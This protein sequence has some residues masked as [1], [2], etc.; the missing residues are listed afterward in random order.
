M[1]L[2]CYTF[3]KVQELFTHDYGEIFNVQLP[4]KEE[5]TKFF[6]DLILKQ[7]SKPPV[8]QKKAG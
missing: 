8:S 7:A 2:M 3:F 4:D 6:E 1:F 5:R